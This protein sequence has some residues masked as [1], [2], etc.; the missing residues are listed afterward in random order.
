MLEMGSRNPKQSFIRSFNTA[1][2]FDTI[3]DIFEQKPI[4][5]DFIRFHTSNLELKTRIDAQQSLW[6]RKNPI[7]YYD[8]VL[9]GFE[10]R[11]GKGTNKNRDPKVPLI[12][13]APLPGIVLVLIQVRDSRF[14]VVFFVLSRCY[15]VFVLDCD[16]VL[17]MIST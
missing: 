13:M 3:V 2:D 11:N 17:W 10:S 16:K 4:L 8:L 7:L 15:L 6:R 1:L 9:R 12:K 5:R 14:K